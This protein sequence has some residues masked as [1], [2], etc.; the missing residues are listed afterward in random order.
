MHAP[1]TQ[2]PQGE[3]DESGNGKHGL[4]A[5]LIGQDAAHQGPV[6]IPMAYTD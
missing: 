4:N 5:D 3:T 6:N 2:D 1:H